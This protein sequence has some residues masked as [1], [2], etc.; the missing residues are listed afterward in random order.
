MNLQLSDVEV[1]GDGLDHPECVCIGPHGSVYAG[2]E[3]G[4]IYRIESQTRGVSQICNIGGF[5][6]GL[7]FDRSGDLFAC[8]MSSRRLVKIAQNGTVSTFFSGIPGQ[9][10]RVP[11]YIVVGRD[12][13]LYLSDSGAWEKTDGCIYAVTP[14]G[15]ARILSSNLQFANG[16]CLSADGK[17]LY[18]VETTGSRVVYVPLNGGA[19]SLVWEVEDTVPDGVA[20]DDDGG[21]WVS[22]YYPMRIYHSSLPGENPQLILEDKRASVLVMPTNIAFDGNWLYIANLGAQFVTRIR[23]PVRGLPLLRN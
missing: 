3:A 1:V 18:V 2:G 13:T 17:G 8:D 19:R 22:C 16:M 4:Q 6:L 23:T 12:D 21:L 10:L 14:S 9:E 11:N 5:V 7:A 15:T 20:L